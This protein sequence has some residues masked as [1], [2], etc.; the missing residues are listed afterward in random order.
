MAIRPEDIVLSK[1]KMF[2]SMRNSLKGKIVNVID[3]GFTYEVH[4]DVMGVIFKALI[5]RNSLVQLNLKEDADVFVS[6][7]AASVHC[8]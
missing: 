3:Q 7:K 1:D 8:F 4:A 6:F 5:T 2:S